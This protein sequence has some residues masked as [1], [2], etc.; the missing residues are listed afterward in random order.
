MPQISP[1]VGLLFDRSRV[2]PLEGV[3][4]PP[5]DTISPEEQR[6]YLQASPHNVI[7]LDLERGFGRIARGTARLKLSLPYSL[8][9][10]AVYWVR[11][12]AV[13]RGEL[14]VASMRVDLRRATGRAPSCR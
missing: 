4:T 13:R 9:R 2:G 1:F 5:Y 12:T 14:T 3:T 10:P 7:R 11:W 8:Q 6:R